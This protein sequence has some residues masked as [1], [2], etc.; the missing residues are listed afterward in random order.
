MILFDSHSGPVYTGISVIPPT[1]SQ[2]PLPH[3]D[4]GRCVNVGAEIVASGLWLYTEC[5]LGQLRLA[6]PEEPGLQTFCDTSSS[7]GTSVKTPVN[8]AVGKAS[9]G[10]CK[11]C[12]KLK[13]G[14]SRC[15]CRIRYHMSVFY[16][17][18]CVGC[19]IYK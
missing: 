8:K 13:L 12:S 11:P 14:C 4:R 9:H 10:F 1:L 5:N 19:A 17:Y 15:R 3:H 2:W 18:M 7:T 16:E 6:S